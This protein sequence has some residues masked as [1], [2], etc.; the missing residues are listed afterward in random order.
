MRRPL[1]EMIAFSGLICSFQSST[2][3]NTN[4]WNHMASSWHLIVCPSSDWRPNCVPSIRP[5]RR[6]HMCSSTTGWRGNWRR[7]R[8]QEP[9]DRCTCRSTS[10]TPP[11][12]ACIKKL[13]LGPFTIWTRTRTLVILSNL[14]HYFDMNC[15]ELCQAYVIIS[16]LSSWCPASS[17][18]FSELRTSW[19][20]RW[21]WQRIEL[22]FNKID[23]VV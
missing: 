18:L 10:G 23:D 13:S 22:S 5:H 7:K 15:A 14:A 3:Q 8:D 6:R 2:Y 4:H 11:V 17:L 9:A 12:S 20:R 16:R 1:A 19:H 21:K